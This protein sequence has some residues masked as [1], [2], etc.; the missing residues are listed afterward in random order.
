MKV[1]YTS[2]EVL[3]ASNNMMNHGGSFMAALGFALLKADKENRQKICATWNA[4]IEKYLHFN[5]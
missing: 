3:L 1:D 5:D 2:T 4:D